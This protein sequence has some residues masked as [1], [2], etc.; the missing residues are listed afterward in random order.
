MNEELNKKRQL[1]SKPNNTSD[2]MVMA[3][4][5][6]KLGE[7]FDGMDDDQDGEISYNHINTQ[8]LTLELQHAFKPLLQELD[9]L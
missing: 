6:K 9:Q 7:I 2:K 3:L 5:K 4:R 8:F 1:I